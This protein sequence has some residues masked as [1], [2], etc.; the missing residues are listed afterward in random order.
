ME[1]TSQ[2]LILHHL[3]KM[4]LEDCSCCKQV[5]PLGHLPCLKIVKMQGMVNVESIEADFYDFTNVHDQCST[6]SSASQVFPQLRELTLREMTSLEK[7]SKP[8]NLSNHSSS[9]CP[10]LQKFQVDQCPKLKCLPNVMTT[11]HRLRRLEVAM[12]DSLDSLLEGVGGLASLEDL[13]IRRLPSLSQLSI[14]C[15]DS[16]E[17]L[18]IG[19]LSGAPE[20]DC[21]GQPAIG[22]RTS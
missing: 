10:L 5:P 4:E 7:W 18:T 11:S 21:N 13:D 17:T 14:G 9:V 2:P 20:F 3:V 15:F 19:D 22:F 16:L 8:A 6:N 1:N 12:C